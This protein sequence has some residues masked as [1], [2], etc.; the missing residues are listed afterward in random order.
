MKTN[1]LLL[2]VILASCANNKDP[3]I[4]PDLSTKISFTVEQSSPA[5]TFKSRV[6]SVYFISK[7]TAVHSHYNNRD[8][9]YI[10]RGKK[11]GLVL[12]NNDTITMQLWFQK[13]ESTKLLYLLDTLS[14]WNKQKWT[15]KSLEDEKL[16]FY[17]KFDEVRI[18]FGS[19]V[20]RYGEPG[21]Y[22]KIENVIKVR[23]QGEDKNYL[24]ISFNGKTYPLYP[25][26]PLPVYTI[27]DGSFKGI[28]D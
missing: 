8:S 13:F 10:S 6:K 26:N 5:K 7:S 18:N 22:F 3:E 17:N 21:G 14:S 19:H 11:Y 1:W 24:E 23:E 2:I 9:V 15:Y 20:L 12:E 25:I 4:I 27:S 28:L 16:L